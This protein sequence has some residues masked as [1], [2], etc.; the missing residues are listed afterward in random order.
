M[1]CTPLTI[2]KLDKEV[3]MKDRVTNDR[4]LAWESERNGTREQKEMVRLVVRGGRGGSSKARE[5]VVYPPSF[6]YSGEDQQLTPGKQSGGAERWESREGYTHSCVSCTQTLSFA[7]NAK[8]ARPVNEEN[9]G[10][11]RVVKI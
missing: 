2:I 9:A 11:G 4:V 8:M 1:L 3:N 5:R 7:T 10:I 6:P